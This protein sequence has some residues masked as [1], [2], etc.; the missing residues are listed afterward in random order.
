[1]TNS[2][3]IKDRMLML[4][5][6]GQKKKYRHL[7]KGYNARLDTIQAEILRV[8]LKHLDRW[9]ES[10]RRCADMYNALFKRVQ[11]YIVLPHEMS[12]ARHVWHLYVIRTKKRDALQKY[13]KEK[14]IYTGIHY[15]IPIH[16]QPAFSDLGYKKGDFPVTEKVSREILS[17]PIYPELKDTQI[18]YIVEKIE[19]FL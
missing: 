2:T 4:R 13:L 11:G 9:N 5:D 7:V 17:L 18:K 8:K 16:L 19:E 15:P 14:N 6:Y 1:M 3:K 12:W 10:R